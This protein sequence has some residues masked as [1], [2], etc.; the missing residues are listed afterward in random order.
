MPQLHAQTGDGSAEGQGEEDQ[1]SVAR[2]RDRYERAGGLEQ[3]EMGAVQG[4]GRLLC[5]RARSAP[6]AVAV[7]GRGSTRNE[8]EALFPQLVSVQHKLLPCP[9]APAGRPSTALQSTLHKATA[10]ASHNA[11][12]SQVKYTRIRRPIHTR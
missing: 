9:A 2:A 7:G 5:V 10:A 12:S 6:I 11:R 3:E 8:H 4:D 1:K